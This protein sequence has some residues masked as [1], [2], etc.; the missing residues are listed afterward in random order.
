MFLPYFPNKW[1]LRLKIGLKDWLKKRE[2]T[3]TEWKVSCQ[4]M[5]LNNDT[6]FRFSSFLQ[7]YHSSILLLIVICNF[8][9][10]KLK[11]VTLFLYYFQGV[12][13]MLD[14]SPGKTWEP[15]EKR[16]NKLVFIGRNLDETALR[17]GFKGC[18]V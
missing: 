5:V 15:N 2:R 17:K 13:S 7:Y 11:F 14:D 12:H 18:L 4:W 8:K 1:W 10:F 6:C 3:Y 9:P 16:I